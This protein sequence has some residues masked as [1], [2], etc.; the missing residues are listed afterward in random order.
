MHRVLINQS[1]KRT[2]LL[3]PAPQPL[4]LLSQPL[5]VAHDLLTSRQQQGLLG[6]PLR[7]RLVQDP[8]HLTS[9]DRR[10]RVREPAAGPRPPGGTAPPLPVS[11]ARAALLG[12]GT[13]RAPPLFVPR[14][15][16]SCQPPSPPSL[17]RL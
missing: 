17:P 5:Q 12:G 7:R 10:E 8:G 1:Q 13:R 15:S 2:R 14:D 4:A 16:N 6:A 11:V 9:G 3:Q